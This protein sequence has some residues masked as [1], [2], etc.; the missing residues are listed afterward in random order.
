MIDVFLVASA[1]A[2][3]FVLA[4]LIARAC[5]ARGGY[6]VLPPWQ[7]T[8]LEVDRETLPALE[9]EVRIHVNRDGERGD[10]PPRS[11]SDTYRVLVAGGSAAECYLLDQ[12]RQW[13]HVLQRHLNEDPRALGA[14]R[15]H[16]GNMSR[17]LVACDYLTL[18]LE[19]ALPRY[20][21]LDL[22]VTFVGAS[23]V[24]A[25]LE[26][27]TPPSIE[28]R[29]LALDYVFPE[30]PETRFGWTPGR[31]ALRRVAAR[32]QRRLLRPETRR[33]GAGKTIAKHRAMRAA[34]KTLIDEV[35]DP[36]PMVA[37]FEH[38]FRRMLTT[39]RASAQRVL[40]V[41]Q[42]WFEKEFTREEAARLWNFGQGRPYEEQLD[43]YYTHRV[44]CE[45]LRAVD[46]VQAR[47][48][49][50]LG[51]EQLDLMPVLERSFDTYY[52]FLHFT[53]AGARAVGRAIADAVLAG[54]AVRLA[55]CS[56]PA[57]A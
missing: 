33:S 29:E 32:L 20:T 24:V 25:W 16:V 5:L 54:G 2:L 27:K 46:A 35:P 22:L 50:E 47:V 14:A 49:Q 12:E 38:H 31:L 56:P 10:P 44:V 7:R 42:P 53:P 28:R 9:P 3:A 39:A 43:T 11:W 15:A 57:G 26:K 23:D 6:Y 36:T 48:A 1:L 51:V 34:A 55:A 4:E 40:V 21:R 37:H 17:S 52:D 45:L 19:K 8:R 30:H 13:P 18:M 41:R